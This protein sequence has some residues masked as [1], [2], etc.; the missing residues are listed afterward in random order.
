[1]Y[2]AILFDFDGTL[3][4]SMQQYADVAARLIHTHTAM[5]FDHARAR[6]LETS[7]LSFIEQLSIIIPQCPPEERIMLD[8]QFHTAKLE[9]L[10]TLR[11]SEYVAQTIRTLKERGYIVVIS[12]NNSEDLLHACVARYN[13]EVDAILGC[14]DAQFQKGK[15]HFDYVAATFH[16]ASHEMLF[17]ADSLKDVELADL[18]AIPFIAKLGTFT[19]QDFLRVLPQIGAVTFIHQL[20]P[21]LPAQKRKICVVLINRAN[22]GRLKPV[23]QAIKEHPDL[24]LQLIVGSSMLIYRYGKSVDIVRADGFH[25]DEELYMQVE[26]ENPQTMAKSLGLAFVELPTMFARLKPD[27]VVVN[28]DR[29]ET[30]AIATCATYLN[31]PV[32]HTLGGE[33]TGTIDDYVRHAVTKMA[34]IHF[35]AHEAAARRVIQ[36]GESPDHV[37]VVG[38]PSLDITRTLDKTLNPQNFWQLARGTGDAFD[39]TQPYILAMQHPVTT[40]YGTNYANTKQ[41][42]E[43]LDTVGM[44]TLMLWPNND[45]GSDEV[46]K[47]MRERKEKGGATLIHFVRNMPVEEY[48]R[49]LA[50]AACIVG[51]SSSG[52]ME[53]GFL[54]VPAVNVGSRQLGREQTRNVI[55]VTPEKNAIVQ[56]IHTQIAHGRFEPDYLFGSG[57]AGKRI[58]EVLATIDVSHRKTFHDYPHHSLT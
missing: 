14:R 56:A 39:L 15:P 22:Y 20:L 31:I 1:M 38:N 52:I 42:L 47:A 51:N 50:H 25:V 10:K 49:L 37:F 41:L 12:S 5:P 55:N 27:I 48:L 32:A 19:H 18:H 17:V 34:D 11:P 24:E 13:F 53:A 23:L 30:I 40:E 8:A 45:A 54:G 35:T 43:A 57:T 2:K 4:E 29:Y 46:T 9:I 58:A 44:P 16:V 7:G 6:Y 33:L 36:M 26:G 28:A 3:I 21:L